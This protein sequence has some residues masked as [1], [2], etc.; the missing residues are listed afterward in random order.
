MIAVIQCAA[1]KRSDAGYLRRQ[2]GMKVMFVADSAKAP[3]DSECAYARPDD[4]SDTGAS[5]REVLVRY[6]A[7]RGNNPLG[8]L[9]ASELYQNAA[10]RRTPGRFQGIH[11]FG[12]MGLNRRVFLDAQL[13]HHV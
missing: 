12:G 4:V 5:W 13:R 11:S 8:L 7:N 3:A 10:Y 6:N 2:D 9:R 1:T